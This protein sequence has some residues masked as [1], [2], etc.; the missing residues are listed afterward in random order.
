VG[1]S[2]GHEW[3]LFVATSGPFIWPTVGTF[4]WPRTVWWVNQGRSFA[5]ELSRQ[6]VFAGT[7]GRTL[8][9]HQVLREMR[10]GDVTLHYVKGLL[11]AVGTVQ[12][13]AIS[14]MRPYVQPLIPPDM[15]FQ[16]GV[17]YFTLATPIPKSEF[18]GRRVGAGPFDRNGVV[19][20]GYCYAVLPDWSEEL[21]RAFAT[22]WPRG[23]LWRD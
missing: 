2:P 12:E 13:E 6:I 19:K 8:H 14:A 3:V 20:L 11:R 18:P 7:E 10:I 16:V 5:P 1:T 22:R 4:S 21:R 23:S 17:T 15:G 9:H